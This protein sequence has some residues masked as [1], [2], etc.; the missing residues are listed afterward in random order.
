MYDLI[1]KLRNRQKWYKIMR[2]E[3]LANMPQHRKCKRLQQGD[4][5]AYDRSSDLACRC[6][7]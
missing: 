1:T 5:H 4:G 3:M 2:M 7:Y 6:M